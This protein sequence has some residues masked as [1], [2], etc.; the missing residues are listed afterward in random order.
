ML[1]IDHLHFYVEDAH[2]WRDWFIKVMGFQS[3][4][5]GN[6]NHSLIEVIRANQIIFVLSSPLTQFSPVARYLRCHPPGVADV[7]FRVS[8]LH[9]VL[10]KAIALDSQL[11]Q[12]L[13]QRG[14]LNWCQIVGVGDLQHTLIEHDKAN[15]LLPYDGLTWQCQPLVSPSFYTHIDHLVVN[16]AAED[17]ESTVTWYEQ[18]FGFV[19]QQN[20]T[21]ATPKSALY[22]QVMIHPQTGVQFPVNKPTSVNSQIQEFLD[23]NQGPGIQHIALFTPNITQVTNKLRSTGLSFL[24]VPFSYYTQLKQTYPQLN[25]SSQEWEQIIKQ[26]ILVDYQPNKNLSVNPILLQI[27]SQPI[28]DQPTLFFELIERRYQAQGFGERNFQALF[29]AMEREQLKRGSL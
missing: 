17:L 28:F 13:Q 3:I 2:Q 19:R 12:P 29:E 23:V 22:S 15:L 16:V 5:S 25:L 1:Q 14:D 6:N 24:S 8:D 4:A 27:F 20:F 11:Q 18:V 7:A 10:T 26:E 9:S 21:I